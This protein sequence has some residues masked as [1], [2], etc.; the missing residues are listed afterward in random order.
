ME[1]LVVVFLVFLMVWMF[2]KIA[3]QFYSIETSAE[4]LD[5]IVTQ[6][7]RDRAHFIV[8]RHHEAYTLPDN[9]EKISAIRDCRQLVEQ[10]EQ[11]FNE[12]KIRLQAEAIASEGKI[13][14]FGKGKAQS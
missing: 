10:Y 8:M 3:V 6:N 4:N 2:V 9:M 7:L 13:L 12:E 14:W 11:A 5:D 1:I